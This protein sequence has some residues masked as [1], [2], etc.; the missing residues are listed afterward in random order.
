[1]TDDKKNL[2]KKIRKKLIIRSSIICAMLLVINTYAW[3]TF[4]TNSDTDVNVKVVSWDISFRDEDDLFKELTI[5][6]DDMYPGM[7]T[8]TK[9]VEI[10]NHSEFNT[11]F[12]VTL[13][14]FTLLGKT[15]SV[16]DS[17]ATSSDAINRLNS[18][19]PFNISMTP[20]ES[21]IGSENTQNFTIEISWPYENP[22]EYYK[23]NDDFEYMSK[24]NYYIL[25][26]SVYSKTDVTESDFA[27]L[28]NA[29][30][31]VESDDADSYYGKKCG[32]YQDS[33]TSC[34]VINLKLK[35]TQ[36]DKA[37]N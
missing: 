1:M 19:Y 31:Y 28:I 34:L 16:P 15:Y 29:G 2:S 5:N 30:L 26:D 18:E 33:E 10:I 23:L 27:N 37:N 7:P 20:T 3:F 21:V 6:L 14:S 17:I 22:N 35:V 12:T 13:D 36:I 4:I 25:A 9:E 24:L 11:S 8:F 32:V